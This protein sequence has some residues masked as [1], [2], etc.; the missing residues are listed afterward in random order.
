MDRNF[1]LTRRSLLRA[2][3]IAGAAAILGGPST[4][5]AVAVPNDDYETTSGKTEPEYDVADAEQHYVETAY[6]LPDAKG[7]GTESPTLF[8]EI[9]WPAD[10]ETGEKI[11]DVPVVLTYS[12]YNDIRSPQS[13]LEST[14]GVLDG[15]TD[16]YVPRGYAR[17]VFDVVGTRNS[18]GCYDYGGYRE[19]IT[20]K[21][22]VEYL[23]G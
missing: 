7:G 18:G 8:G 9:A 1:D 19:R 23:V 10:P 17:A 3:T 13:E 16:Y 12:P 6:S 4:G 11:K 5:G 2:S 15:T 22:L 14:T 20:G 21:K